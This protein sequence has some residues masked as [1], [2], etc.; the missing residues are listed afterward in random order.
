MIWI[1]SD[2]LGNFEPS[3]LSTPAHGTGF[4]ESF[5]DDQSAEI[6]VW[7]FPGS[8]PRWAILADSG[9]GRGGNERQLDGG[10]CYVLEQ[11]LRFEWIRQD[12][13]F[14]VLIMVSG[15]IEMPCGNWGGFA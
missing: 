1:E 6:G 8:V 15:K 12:A 3:R 5:H 13:V 4:F 7:H 9:I 10:G 11:K 2:P 14:L